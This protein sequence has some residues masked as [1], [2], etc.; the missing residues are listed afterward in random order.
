MPL[1]LGHSDGSMPAGARSLSAQLENT[2]KI[3]G[4]SVSHAADMTSSYN[5][6]SG[7]KREKS[8]RE[9]SV[10]SL[11]RCR[12][13]LQNCKII[14]AWPREFHEINNGSCTG[15]DR[16]GISSGSRTVVDFSTLS[17][18]RSTQSCVPV[19]LRSRQLW[20][21]FRRALRST[22]AACGRPFHLPLLTMRPRCSFSARPPPAHG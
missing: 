11:C 10:H 13:A 8:G 16:Q 6:R 1:L 3:H 14:R 19:A 4:G 18:H 2:S 12:R 7:E 20:Q 5:S 17:T 22:A 15:V 21:R 9:P